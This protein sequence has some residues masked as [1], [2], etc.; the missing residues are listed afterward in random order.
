MAAVST[1][2]LGWGGGGRGGVGSRGGG[3]LSPAGRMLPL[4][5]SALKAGQ[6]QKTGQQEVGK[7]RPGGHMWTAE[8]F[9]PVGIISPTAKLGKF[10]S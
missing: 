3:F 10:S 4:S 2:A 9:N 1:S 8:P 5:P 7:L 6:G